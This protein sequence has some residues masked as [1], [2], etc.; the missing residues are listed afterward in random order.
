MVVDIGAQ[1]MRVG[2]LVARTRRNQESL[3][4]EPAISERFARMVSVEGESSLEAA[5][6]LGIAR[7]PAAVRRHVVA[8]GE[9]VAKPKAL[10]RQ[11]GER[12]RRL[13]DSEARMSAA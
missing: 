11:I 2:E 9:A 13:T 3:G 12:C 7:E 4:V 5:A 10:E 6:N 1:P 8:V